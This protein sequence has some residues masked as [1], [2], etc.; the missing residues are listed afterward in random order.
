MFET[1]RTLLEEGEEDFIPLGII[2]FTFYVRIPFLCQWMENFG[3]EMVKE[4]DVAG[5]HKLPI[6][7]YLT[8]TLPPCSSAAC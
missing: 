3:R 8:T 5:N 1:L 2:T 6:L 7:L 4:A